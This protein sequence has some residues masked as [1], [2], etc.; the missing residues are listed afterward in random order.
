MAATDTMAPAW[1]S[2]AWAVGADDADQG[3]N[4]WSE[5]AENT[6]D[7][8]NGLFFA[9]YRL[10]TETGLYH[11][12]HRSYHPTLGRWFER[13]PAGYQDGPSLYQVAHSNPVR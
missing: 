7:W 5:D 11:V 13:D 6:S 9:G 10:D 12:R 8:D 3:V 2:W 4:D 1:C